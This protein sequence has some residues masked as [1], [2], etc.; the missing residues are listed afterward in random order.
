MNLLHEYAGGIIV[1][2]VLA[3]LLENIL[4]ETGQKKYIQI[5]IGLLVMLAI[6]SPLGNLIQSKEIFRLP[7]VVIDDSDLS[8]GKNQ[9]VHEDFKRRLCETLHEQVMMQ[10]G[11][12]I[13]ISVELEINDEGAITEIKEIRFFPYDI[14]TAKCLSE[15]S[16]ISIEKIKEGVVE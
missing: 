10:T 3:I 16:G 11:K 13:D 5:S 4:P 8:F 2:S 6:I 1:V 15:L 12:E 7:E 9:Y 14:E